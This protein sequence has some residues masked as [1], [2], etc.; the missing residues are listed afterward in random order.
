MSKKEEQ[1]KKEEEQR[2]FTGKGKIL[3]M[4]DEQMIREI[5]GQML[6]KLGYEVEFARDGE[7]AIK[8]YSKAKESRETFDAVIMDLTVPGGMG[9]KEAIQRLKEID[10]KVKA[11]VS[12]GYFNDPV[13]SDFREY[14]FRGVF[15]KPYKIEDL[16]RVLHEVLK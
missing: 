4:D 12:S 16:S 6:R 1:A 11:I 8:L 10:P 7:E 14:G 3:F 13:M 5:A 9:G 15:A 2:L